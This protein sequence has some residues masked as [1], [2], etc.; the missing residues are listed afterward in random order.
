MQTSDLFALR[1]LV[2]RLFA[3]L[4][5]ACASPDAAAR[6]L[7]E[8]G[9]I[10]PSTVTAFEKLT[11]TLDA[12]EQILQTIDNVSE[13]ANDDDVSNAVLS[14]L[15]SLNT[16]INGLNGIGAAIQTDFA[17]SPILTQTD[18]VADVSRKLFDYLI[19]QL[20]ETY[21]TTLNAALNLFGIIETETIDEPQSDFDAVYV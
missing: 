21:Y 14:T 4:E 16:I 13:D 20:I 9:Y 8:L 10:A 2:V 12:L 3:P 11:P 15:D 1:Q 5:Q 17:G 7:A 6:L 19:A 18:I